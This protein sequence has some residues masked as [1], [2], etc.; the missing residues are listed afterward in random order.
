MSNDNLW[1]EEEP[2]SDMPEEARTV[3]GQPGQATV[4]PQQ[5]SAPTIPP[6]SQERQQAIERSNAAIEALNSRT[7]PAYEEEQD[8]ESQEDE[9]YSEVLNDANLRLEQGSLYK[10]IMKH[11]LFADTDAD[12][13]A[14]QNVQ[15]AIRK[16]AREQ[17]EIMLGMRQDPQTATIE[18]LEIDFPFNALE[19]TTLKALAR[20]ATKGKTDESDNFV[21]EVKRI[22][23]DVPTAPKR[24]SFTPIGSTSS[25][26]TSPAQKPLASR[27]SAPVK[28]SKLDDVIDQVAREEG[29]PR[30]LLE[31]NQLLN[32]PV[33]E[34]TAVEL[35]ERD[36]LVSK[37]RGTQVK[38]SQA[39]PMP[40]LE[41]QNQMIETRAPTTNKLV[42]LALKMPPSKLL[43]SGE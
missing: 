38:S 19:V 24:N 5:Y 27:P 18:R 41:Q 32:K 28:R 21:P 3:N 34:L 29:I 1:G 37:R 12:P 43:N 25:K 14:V 40:T 7:V 30:E 16:F 2:F 23:Q 6:K 10:L 15:K 31:E 17:M 36:K 22:T 8:E 35:L 4:T 9:D 39:L 33:K 42:E 26:K 11:E 13:K 20:T